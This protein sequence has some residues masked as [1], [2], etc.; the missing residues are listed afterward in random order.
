MT[1]WG[2][3]ESRYRLYL[4]STIKL[5]LDQVQRVPGHGRCGMMA[6][7]PNYPGEGPER[8]GIG[9]RVVSPFL[10]ASTIREVLIIPS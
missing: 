10:I 3:Q 6:L 7:R 9:P 5:R 8:T 4:G 2:T 1:M